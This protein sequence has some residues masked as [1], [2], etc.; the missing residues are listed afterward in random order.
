MKKL[1]ALL[2]ILVLLS[3]S[4]DPIEPNGFSFDG[5][6]YPVKSLLLQEYGDNQTRLIFTGANSVEFGL[7]E[8]IVE[9][10]VN[11]PSLQET[12]HNIATNGLYRFQAEPFFD[13][14]V[15]D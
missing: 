6:L 13:E 11:S 1:T 7:P 9:I 4:S 15:Y 14:D 2:A 3:C 5:R 12:L 10:N 8:T